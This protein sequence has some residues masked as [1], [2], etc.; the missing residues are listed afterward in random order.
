MVSVAE[1]Q[2]LGL[3]SDRWV[4]PTAA[5]ESNAMTVLPARAELHRS[6]AVAAMGRAALGHVDLTI[7]RVD[8]LDLYSCFP[9]AVQ[10]QALELG[11]DLDR[12][13]TVTGGM[14]FGGGPLNNYV[15]QATATMVERLREDPGSTGMVTSVSGMLTKTGV[16][17]WSSAA[18]TVPF[19]AIDVSDVVTATTALRPFDPDAT[20][21]ATIVGSTVVHDRGL[22]ARAVVVAELADG[23]RTVAVGRDRDVAVAMTTGDWCGRSVVVGPAGAFEPS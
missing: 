22:P 10:V 16:G 2:R 7:D 1:A 9:A 21:M 20:G 3:A 23:H 8:H 12:S 17:L 15:L 18:P 6:P 13:L 4:F 14:T 11:L 5:A 19:A